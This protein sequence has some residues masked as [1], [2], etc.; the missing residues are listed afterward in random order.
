MSREDWE[1]SH[2]IPE[3]DH[4]GEVVIKCTRHNTTFYCMEVC[5]KCYEELEKQLEEYQDDIESEY[6]GGHSGKSAWELLPK[7][8]YPAPKKEGG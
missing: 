4:E 3:H 7:K 8:P 2:V 6:G 5:P 1:R